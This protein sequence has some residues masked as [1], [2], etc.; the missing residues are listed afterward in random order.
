MALSTTMATNACVEKEGGRAGLILIGAHPKVVAQ[1]GAAYDLPGKDKLCLLDGRPGSPL[2]SEHP[3]VLPKLQKLAQ[4]G[5]ARF[6]PQ[7][8]FIVLLEMPAEDG[9]YDEQELAICRALAKEPLRMEELAEI[10]GRSVYALP[11]TRLEN[12]GVIIRSGLT[13]TDI[14][15]L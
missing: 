5:A 11:L 2:A 15:H 14:M 6:L 7:H 1:N 4:L 8:E 9:R 10:V 3:A 12:E 13:P